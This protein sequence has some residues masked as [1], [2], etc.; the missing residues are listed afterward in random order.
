MLAARAAGDEHGGIQA[1]LIVE[2]SF[3]T[4]KHEIVK[5]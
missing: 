2:A 1:A 5:T 3:S 4:G